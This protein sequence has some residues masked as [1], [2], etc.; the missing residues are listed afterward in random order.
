MKKKIIIFICIT[1]GILFIL[2]SRTLA[3]E[4]ITQEDI[5]RQQQDSLNISN[6]INEAEKYS[7]EVFEDIDF[8]ELFN[9]A[10]TRKY[11]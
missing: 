3:E 5:I 4:K 1:V 10:L 6:F 7:D 2:P 11:R 9:M 8:N